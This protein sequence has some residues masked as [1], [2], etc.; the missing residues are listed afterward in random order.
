[1]NPEQPSRNPNGQ[2]NTTLFVHHEDT[3]YA[4]IK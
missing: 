4:E 1:M 2:D 3:A